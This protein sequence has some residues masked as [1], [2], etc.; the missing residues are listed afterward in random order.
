MID[1]ED[2][3]EERFGNIELNNC[4]EIVVNYLINKLISY[5]VY[6]ADMKKI[7]CN[8]NSHCYDV[9]TKKVV[10]DLIQFEYIA[11]DKDEFSRN[12]SSDEKSLF[13]NQVYF[14]S[15]N[16]L[17]TVEPVNIVIITETAENR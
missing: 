8:I 9:F 14:G 12:K 1:L 16:W 2:Y 4:S 5:T 15:N 7:E 11:Y 3:T 6:E 13:F 10:Q 17:Q